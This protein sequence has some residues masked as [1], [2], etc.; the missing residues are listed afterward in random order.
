MPSP[1]HQA[2]VW[3]RL[4][5]EGFTACAIAAVLLFA[6]VA[7]CLFSTDRIGGCDAEGATKALELLRDTTQWLASIQTAT[8]AAL[9]LIAKDGVPSLKLRPGQVK[10]VIAVV[11]LNCAALFCAAWVLTALPSMALRI[12]SEPQRYYDF[13]ESPIYHSF[14][15]RYIVEYLTVRLFA[16]CNHWFWALGIV[17]FGWLCLSMTIVRSRRRQRAGAAG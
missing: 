14:E 12:Q 17:F 4:T 2:S 10:L 11:V 15:D 7:A 13:F 9:G 1:S 16:F 6:V 3:R 5:A 8:L